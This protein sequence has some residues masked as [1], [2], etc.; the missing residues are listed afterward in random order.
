MGHHGNLGSRYSDVK[1]AGDPKSERETFENRHIFKKVR[2]NLGPGLGV[3]SSLNNKLLN[4]L[5]ACL[6]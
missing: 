4:R 6:F 5:T 2:K 1:G 3:K